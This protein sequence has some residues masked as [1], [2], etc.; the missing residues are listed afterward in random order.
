MLRSDWSRPARAARAT[1][2]IR[3]RLRDLSTIAGVDQR[4]PIPTGLC[5]WRGESGHPQH[6]CLI[7]G[8][9]HTHRY[10]VSGLAHLAD[11]S[12]RRPLRTA[13]CIRSAIDNL[14]SATGL[15]ARSPPTPQRRNVTQDRDSERLA[16]QASTRTVSVVAGG[17][18]ESGARPVLPPSAKRSPRT[19]SALTVTLPGPQP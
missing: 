11:Q 16:F 3:V 4:V 5:P 9:A 18:E 13:T 12:L 10:Q 8:I 15:T 1:P 17:G 2:P 19:V 14:T 6:H 7:E